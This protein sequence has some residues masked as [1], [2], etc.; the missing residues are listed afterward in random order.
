MD[1]YPSPWIALAIMR[2]ASPCTSPWQHIRAVPDG[3][4]IGKAT[5]RAS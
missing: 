4:G 2:V 5:L 3:P 1:N